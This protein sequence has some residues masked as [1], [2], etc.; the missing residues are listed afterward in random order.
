[1][2]A[3]DK[4]ACA[5]YVRLVDLMAGVQRCLRHKRGLPPLRPL[6]APGRLVT[7]WADA[8]RQA[9]ALLHQ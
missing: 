7:H 3:V 6:K 9:S 5:R 8:A 4:P 2:H 1:M